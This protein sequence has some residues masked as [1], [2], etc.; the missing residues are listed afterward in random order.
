MDRLKRCDFFSH[1]NGK[2]FLSQHQAVRTLAGTANN[3]KAAAA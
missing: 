3:N 1:L 2:V